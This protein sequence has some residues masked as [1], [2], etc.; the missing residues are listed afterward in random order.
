MLVSA[1][2]LVPLFY[3]H[4]GDGVLIRKDKLRVFGKALFGLAIGADKN[5]GLIRL[6]RFH[7]DELS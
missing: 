1:Y 4:L 7:K 3:Q 6:V 2:F 5:D